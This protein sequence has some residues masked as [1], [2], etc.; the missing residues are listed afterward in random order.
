MAKATS[1]R[2]PILAAL[3]GA[4]VTGLGHLYL[5]RWRRA[6][7]W[8]AV[9]YAATVLFVPDQAVTAAATGGPVRPLALAPIALVGALSAL[10]A[11]RI[12][13][14]EQRPTTGPAADESGRVDCPACGRS[15]DPELG[16]CHW[17]TT[18]FED[19][20]V[21]APDDRDETGTE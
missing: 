1:A 7:G 14:F 2:R 21:V 15:I 4:V 11:Y 9:G 16:F 3:L 20:R 12:A 6:V 5:R 10:D 8:A 17:C 18:E 13:L 19:L